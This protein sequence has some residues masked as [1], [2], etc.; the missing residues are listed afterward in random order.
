MQLESLLSLENSV[1]EVDAPGLASL[2]KRIKETEQKLKVSIICQVRKF[3]LTCVKLLGC[4]LG[5]L[6][7][8]KIPAGGSNN[9]NNIIKLLLLFN[10]N[11]NNNIIN[12]NKPKNKQA[13]KQTN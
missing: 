13:K 1:D 8:G 4:L 5:I 9:K 10:N 7:L 11:I 12:N 2:Q 6:P 3:L